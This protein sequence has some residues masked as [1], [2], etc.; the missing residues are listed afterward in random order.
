[1]YGTHNQT[2]SDQ[3]SSWSVYII[4]FQSRSKN[5]W[6]FLQ[7]VHCFNQLLM[8]IFNRCLRHILRIYC[9]GIISTEG[10]CQSRTYRPLD[11]EADVPVS[12][13][14]YVAV[15]RRRIVWNPQEQRKIKERGWPEKEQLRPKL[16]QKK[17]GRNQ[18][19]GWK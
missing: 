1:M 4:H 11:Q 10:C 5:Q 3:S 8:D 14:D 15:E 2:S 16:E 6:N 13:T 7:V 19:L 17:M 9:P 12:G 18:S